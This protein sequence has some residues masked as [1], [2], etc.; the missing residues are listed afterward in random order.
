MEPD[1]MEIYKSSLNAVGTVYCVGKAPGDKKE[2]RGLILDTYN[3]C[4]KCGRPIEWLEK[5]GRG[6]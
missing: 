3:Y 4:P 5:E 2:C 6:R 1:T